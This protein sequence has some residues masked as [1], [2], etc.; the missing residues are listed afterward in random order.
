MSVNDGIALVVALSADDGVVGRLQ[1]TMLLVVLEVVL[2][3]LM[4]LPLTSW[5]LLLVLM[6]T[7]ELA[8]E[9]EILLPSILS[10][11]IV[12]P[13]VAAAEEDCC[14]CFLSLELIWSLIRFVSSMLE[15]E[16][17]LPDWLVSSCCCGWFP[18]NSSLLFLFRLP[19]ETC[20]WS[21]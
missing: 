17:V 16:L 2:V 1:M 5:M 18:G 8:S 4:V 19:P 14:C 10:L 3:V 9:T 7:Y 11:T 20:L 21:E 6:P 12:L 15:L 13:E